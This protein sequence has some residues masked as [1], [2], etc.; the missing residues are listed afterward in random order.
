M[1]WFRD[2]L[3]GCWDGDDLLDG[4]AQPLDV[5]APVQDL[6]GEEKAAELIPEGS[7]TLEGLRSIM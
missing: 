4:A 6:D 5:V 3:Q 1:Q 2:L 7:T